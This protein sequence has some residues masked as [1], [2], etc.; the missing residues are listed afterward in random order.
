MATVGRGASVAN[1]SH[2]TPAYLFGLL[3][4]DDFDIVAVEVTDGDF[5]RS[6]SDEYRQCHDETPCVSGPVIEVEC[7]LTSACRVF[8]NSVS[9]NPVERAMRVHCSQVVSTVP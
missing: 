3:T 7:Y 5:D 4:L 6:V 8:L 2:N 1:N 9:R